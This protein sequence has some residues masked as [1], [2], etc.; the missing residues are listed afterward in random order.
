[1]CLRIRASAASSAV[2]TVVSMQFP[3]LR[4]FI[5][6]IDASEVLELAGPGLLVEA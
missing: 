6:A 3:V 5:G 4:R 1:M 2:M